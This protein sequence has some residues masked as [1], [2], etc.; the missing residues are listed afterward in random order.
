M[1]SLILSLLL[2]SSAATVHAQNN[3][4][5]LTVTD[6]M[7]IKADYFH[8]RVNVMPDY[9][10]S[11]DTTG[12]R[13]DPDFARKRAEKLQR[14]QEEHQ[15]KIESNLKENGFFTEPITINE[16][17]FRNAPQYF[18]TVS[19]NSIKALQYLIK[20]SSTERGVSFN[21]LNLSAKDEDDQYKQLFKKVLAKARER[22]SF[23][24][25]L[26]NKKITGVLSISDK[27]LENQYG[28]TAASLIGGAVI[29]KDSVKTEEGILNLF[30]ITS[31][32]TVKFSMQ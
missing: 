10:A 19:T 2:L 27:R 8:I 22:A 25:G 4:I 28:Y 31:T 7:L 30:P 14:K 15:R 12:M 6:T 20:L 29:R 18:F 13:T 16:L 17:A 23:I 5:E 26:Q 21:L 32:I 1:R 3:V 9:E 11:L 24:A